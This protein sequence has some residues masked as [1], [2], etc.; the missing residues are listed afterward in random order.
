MQRYK[1]TVLFAIIAI[2]LIVFAFSQAQPK[3]VEL[4]NILSGISSKKTELT[5][6]ERQLETL[7]ASAT[8]RDAQLAGQV[9]KIYKPEFPGMEAESS[10]TV[11]FDDLI[12]MAKYNGVKIYSI[13]YVYN[14]P[15]DEFVKGAP[16]RYNVCQLSIQVIGDYS[17]LESFFKE[18]YKYPYLV[19]IDKI[20]LAPYEKNKVVILGNIQLKLY[21]SK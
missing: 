4:F 21:T 15:E 20:E 8:Q 2:C 10:F 16:D 7:K 13:E 1:D 19:N 12:E 18:V 6:A 9:K 14:P 5:D 3:I 11:M 17:D